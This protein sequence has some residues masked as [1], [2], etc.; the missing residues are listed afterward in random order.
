MTSDFAY[1]EHPNKAYRAGPDSVKAL[2]TRLDGYKYTNFIVYVK[3][4][5]QISETKMV[6][7]ARL[8]AREALATN[9]INRF[10]EASMTWVYIS[11][12]WYLSELKDLTEVTQA[13]S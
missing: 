13:S 4:T 2:Y 3:E 10:W 6:V 1:V 11:G 7:K 9:T 5:T 12:K 8:Q